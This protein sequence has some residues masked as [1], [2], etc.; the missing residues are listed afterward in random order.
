MK[1]SALDTLACPYD[2]GASNQLCL[3]RIH[4]MRLNITNINFDTHR[5]TAIQTSNIFKWKLNSR[6]LYIHKYWIG[7]IYF[8]DDF[9]WCR[10]C[11]LYEMKMAFGCF[12]DERATQARQW[13][14]KSRL[15][16]ILSCVW[17]MRHNTT[18]KKLT[19]LADTTPQ[20]YENSTCMMKIAKVACPT[21]NIASKMENAKL[22]KRTKWKNEKNAL[23]AASGFTKQFAI[24]WTWSNAKRNRNQILHNSRSDKMAPAGRIIRK[25]LLRAIDENV[26]DIKEVE[27]RIK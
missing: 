22:R 8:N 10:R 16:V 5:T 2:A 27:N 21:S 4:T 18:E 24:Y 17:V 15:H 19:L 1:R 23:L 7:C 3:L 11:K 14:T 26:D 9:D 6:Q 13:A 20:E 25:E 12:L